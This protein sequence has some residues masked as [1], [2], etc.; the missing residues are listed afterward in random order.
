MGRHVDIGRAF[1]YDFSG[2]ASNA[3]EEVSSGS[4]SGNRAFPSSR[5]FAWHSLHGYWRI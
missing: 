5:T 3:I 2:G 4:V 1:E